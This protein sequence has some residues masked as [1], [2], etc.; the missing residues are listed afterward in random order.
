MFSATILS[1]LYRITTP[2]ISMLLAK[3][4]SARLYPRIYFLTGPGQVIFVVDLSPDK[5]FHFPAVNRGNV[6]RGNQGL[7]VL[8]VQA[9]LK[10]LFSLTA[11]GAENLHRK[12]AHTDQFT[13][14]L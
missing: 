8:H 11:E 13:G 3:S 4:V 14:R 1:G 10:H 7:L 6:C 9:L 5:V 12:L 2:A